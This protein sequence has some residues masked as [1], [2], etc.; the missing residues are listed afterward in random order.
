[1][2]DSTAALRMRA[3][4]TLTSHATSEDPPTPAIVVSEWES[5][6]AQLSA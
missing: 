3:V 2:A 6:R 5:S 4:P 1:V